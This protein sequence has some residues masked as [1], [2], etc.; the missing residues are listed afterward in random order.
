MDTYLYDRN[1]KKL[2]NSALAKLNQQHQQQQH[3]DN[4]Q[5]TA[6]TDR[7]EIQ[8][9]IRE[10]RAL[11]AARDQM[12]DAMETESFHSQ[13]YTEETRSAR[14]ESDNEMEDKRR[15]HPHSQ[16]AQHPG[17]PQVVPEDAMT[18]GLRGDSGDRH[19]GDGHH[20]DGHHGD[21]H[22]A[23]SKSMD[24]VT[25]RATT[26]APS[27]FTDIEYEID[28]ESVGIKDI[29]WQQK[30]RYL[31]NRLVFLE[32]QI[33][34]LPATERKL[35]KL[36]LYAA[37]EFLSI[38][39]DEKKA[40]DHLVEWWDLHKY[41]WLD[42]HDP[43]REN[44]MAS[45][46]WNEIGIP[47][48]R[49]PNATPTHHNKTVFQDIYENL[50]HIEWVDPISV[51]LNKYRH[52]APGLNGL[53]GFKPNGHNPLNGLNGLSGLKQNGHNGI[54]H[55]QHGDGD[56]EDAESVMIPSTIQFDQTKYKDYDRDAVSHLIDGTEFLR[57]LHRQTTGKM[58]RSKTGLVGYVNVSVEDKVAEC[59]PWKLV[60]I[61]KTSVNN[62]IA[63]GHNVE[64]VAQQQSLKATVETKV[65]QL[66]SYR[67]KI[68]E[69]EQQLE[70]Q[71]A[72]QEQMRKRLEADLEAMHRVSQNGSDRNGIDRN[73]TSNGKRRGH[74]HARQRSRTSDS[75]HKRP[76]N[77]YLRRGAGYQSG[78]NYRDETHRD[79]V[80]ASPS[81]VSGHSHISYD[82]ATAHRYS[83][84][85]PPSADP[86][87]NTAAPPQSPYDGGNEVYKSYEEYDSAGHQGAHSNPNM[88]RKRRNP[89]RNSNQSY[90][91]KGGGDRNGK[92]QG[93]DR[94]GKGNPPDVHRQRTYHAETTDSSHPS[95]HFSPQ[96][97]S[98]S[99]HASSDVHRRHFTQPLQAAADQAQQGTGPGDRGGSIRRNDRKMRGHKKG[100]DITGIYTGNGPISHHRSHR[101]YYDEDRAADAEVYSASDSQTLHSESTDKSPEHN[102]ED[103]AYFDSYS[104]S[105]P[106]RHGQG[107]MAL[108][109]SYS[110]KHAASNEGGGGGGNG[111]HSVEPQYDRIRQKSSKRWSPRQNARN[112][113]NQQAFDRLHHTKRRDSNMS[114]STYDKSSASPPQ[115]PNLSHESSLSVPSERKDVVEN[116]PRDRYQRDQSYRDRD[117]DRD[118]GRDRHRD[119]S[120][121]RERERERDRDRN[122]ND[123]RHHAAPE[124]QQLY[125][126]SR[127][128]RDQY[129]SAS[130]G[131]KRS[132][133]SGSNISSRS[134]PNSKTRAKSKSSRRTTPLTPEKTDD[135]NKLVDRGKRGRTKPSPVPQQM[136]LSNKQKRDMAISRNKRA[137]TTWKLY[138]DRCEYIKTRYPEEV[139]DRNKAWLQWTKM[140][141]ERDKHPKQKMSESQLWSFIDF[142]RMSIARYANWIWWPEKPEHAKVDAATLRSIQKAK[143]ARSAETVNGGDS[144]RTYLSQR[145]YFDHR[146][147]LIWTK[148]FAIVMDFN[149]FLFESY[150]NPANIEETLA[151]EHSLLSLASSTNVVLSKKNTK[152]FYL[153]TSGKS[154]YRYLQFRCDGQDEED[155]DAQRSE[156]MEELDY[157]IHIV[158]DLLAIP[159]IKLK[160]ADP[161]ATV[162]LPTP[163]VQSTPSS[164]SNLSPTP[165]TK[166]AAAAP[167][168]SSSLHSQ[169][170]GNV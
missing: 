79:E 102:R 147:N 113:A 29:V 2:T 41:S 136:T 145:Q 106:P 67:T 109:K 20:G 161:N 155:D 129:R 127:S 57:F 82:P 61:F 86:M 66:E 42:R 7:A 26:Y 132:K 35:D 15:A 36:M 157:Q 141:D 43:Q 84:S 87:D 70:R 119:R 8:Q 160:V 98:K 1:D 30:M 5:M 77:S 55:N 10:S 101:G 163:I 125:G 124:Q 114:D 154:D 50:K 12:P 146:L 112:H 40:N 85:V 135:D 93:R 115:R 54:S 37:L 19:H 148:K 94:N 60:R 69:L 32:E 51:Q 126:D 44:T 80:V 104:H 23:R 31:Q 97:Q 58:A 89:Q 88:K 137:L 13:I 117:R 92:G 52:S 71:Q 170:T 151:F 46:N 169:K 9:K 150:A 143:R 144:E 6:M 22:H 11:A 110:A 39:P 25:T 38:N 140:L 64:L 72:E 153:N 165:A 33:T 95:R 166:S 75:P 81:G 167:A 49:D 91:S 138:V 24:S 18:D 131:S 73:G 139:A 34:A 103:E 27:I 48:T 142:A 83:H 56:S 100:K 107:K 62:R 133:Q 130:K 122:R 4:H 99:Y 65:E 47:L 105:K 90:H 28:F 17:H 123:H 59:T 134:K 152:D 149:L 45:Q 53:N 116:K 156:W 168:L 158:H 63:Y 164:P 21:G 3:E 108:V 78:D 76:P 128:A 96:K 16:H 14:Y 159:G 120:R 111:I 68:A 121:H 118:R 162:W 74:R